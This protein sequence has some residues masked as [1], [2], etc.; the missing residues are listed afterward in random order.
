MKPWCYVGLTQARPDTSKGQVM[1]LTGLSKQEAIEALRDNGATDE[2]AESVMG[3]LGS[4]CYLVDVSLPVR[5]VTVID[6]A[7]GYTVAA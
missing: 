7:E 1:F 4:G 2:Q 6:Q 3:E 5:D